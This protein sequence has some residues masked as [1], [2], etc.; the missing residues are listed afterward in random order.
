ME[1]CAGGWF[2]EKLRLRKEAI[3]GR[4]RKAEF[5]KNEGCPSSQEL[6][7]FQNG[8]LSVDEGRGIRLHLRTCEFCTAEAEFYAHY[9]HQAAITEPD[10]IPEPLYELAS[11]L[12][13]KDHDDLLMMDDVI[14]N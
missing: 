6:Y 9:P 12:L 1:R 4:A 14:L 2:Q 13:K 7:A 3:M 11:A 5:C 8:D 10:R